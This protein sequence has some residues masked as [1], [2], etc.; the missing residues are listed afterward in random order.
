MKTILTLLFV[1]LSIIS[2]NATAQTTK[3]LT[4]DLDKESCI[5]QE[6]EGK[7]IT[8]FV[9]NVS[10]DQIKEIKKTAEKLSSHSSLTIQKK[11]GL[12]ICTISFT[13]NKDHNIDKS[14]LQKLLFKLGIQE[15]KYNNENTSVNSLSK[16]TN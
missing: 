16:I 11:R 5:L 7:L 12:Y 15:V 6:K 1:T 8:K 3:H 10:S 4:A 2:N 9:L 13:P 14:F